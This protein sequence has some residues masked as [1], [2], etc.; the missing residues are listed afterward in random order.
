MNIHLPF[1]DGMAENIDL[2]GNRQ[3]LLAH[4]KGIKVF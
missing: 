4:Y 1:T 2:M 3:R